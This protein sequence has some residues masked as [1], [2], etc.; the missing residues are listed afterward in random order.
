[1]KYNYFLL[2]FVS[3]L[4]LNTTNI[5]GQHTDKGTAAAN[6]VK[7]NTQIAGNF[8]IEKNNARTGITEH[9]NVNC[10]ISPAPFKNVLNLELGTADPILFTADIV[11]PR[12]NKVIHWV[13]SEKSHHYK[14]NI[15]ISQLAAGD[16][17]LN[18]YCEYSPSLLQSI[19][20]Q[21]SE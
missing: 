9:I 7:N 13:P 6:L 16:Y 17:H 18:I 15:D 10:V 14:D 3:V 12:G 2:I 11:D 20:F 5:F 21:K 4:L 19:S 1:M 8:E